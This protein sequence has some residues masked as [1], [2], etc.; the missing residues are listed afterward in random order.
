MDTETRVFIIFMW[1]FTMIFP[2]TTFLFNEGL[3]SGKETKCFN[4]SYQVVQF[5][6]Y[7][8][9][10]CCFIPLLWFCNITCSIAKL[11]LIFGFKS[12]HFLGVKKFQRLPRRKIYQLSLTVSGHGQPRNQNHVKRKASKTEAILW[13]I[14]F[15]FKDK[16]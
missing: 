7:H 8:L 15:K 4:Y 12:S 6:V 10:Y 9:T 11:Y 1:P 16:L 13:S 14:I 2:S 3:D 5:I